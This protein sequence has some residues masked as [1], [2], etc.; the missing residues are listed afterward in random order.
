MMNSSNPTLS[1]DK[2]RSASAGTLDGRPIEAPDREGGPSKPPGGGSTATVDGTMNK[3]GILGLFVAMSFYGTWTLTATNVNTG[4][5]IAGVAALIGVVLSLVISFKM[6]LAPVLAIP[7]A[8]AEGALM[9]G[10]S[11]FYETAFNGIVIQAVLATIAVV[12]AMYSLWKAGIIRLGPRGRRVVST[13][14]FGIF[15]VFMLS[16]A[17][18]LFGVGMPLIFDGGPIA[19][20]FSLLVIGIA[21]LML[22][23]DFDPVRSVDQETLHME[24]I[25]IK[26]NRMAVFRF[27]NFRNWQVCKLQ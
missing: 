21:S 7:F 22:T 11:R 27:F 13:A 16:W 3:F 14:F 18:S 25:H 12:A 1:R 19:I 23:I 24:I 2:L 26:A 17:L 20:G 10:V 4:L 8:L 5:A 6:H 9:G 15:L